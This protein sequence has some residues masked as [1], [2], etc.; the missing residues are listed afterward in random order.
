[1]KII[2]LIAAILICTLSVS[3]QT[4]KNISVLKG[5][6]IEADGGIAIPYV[7]IGIP[8]GNCGTVADKDGRFT[9]VVSDS[10]F[11]N[12]IRVS[13]LGYQPKTFTIKELLTL[14]THYPI[15]KLNKQDH[16]LSEVVIKAKKPRIKIIGGTSK[17]KSLSVGFP[18]K[19]LGSEV[20]T[21][22]S[23]GKKDVLALSF[24]CNISINR[25]D[26]GVFRLNIY[27][28]K[29]GMPTKNL[30]RQNI[31]L[32]IGRKTGPCKI[33]LKPYNIVLKDDVL[34]SLEWITGI[35]TVDR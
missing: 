9:L 27:E 2:W 18:I 1:M 19:L 21:V 24:N 22:V 12:I 10:L 32:S 28:I 5:Q 34:I 23:L 30:L 15:I 35:T 33:D 14:L 31:I 8:A 26:T 7:S 17:S 13:S 11:N 29:D 20:G 25:L 3:A 6:I 4:N 16:E